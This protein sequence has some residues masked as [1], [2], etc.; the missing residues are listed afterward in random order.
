MPNVYLS[1]PV[2]TWDLDW[3]AR[4]M[5]RIDFGIR[6]LSYGLKE[7]LLWSDQEHVVNVWAAEITLDTAAE[8]SAFDDFTEDLQG[9]LVGFWLPAPEVALRVASGVDEQTFD[10]VEAGLADSFA[11]LGRTR[12]KVRIRGKESNR[13]GKPSTRQVRQANRWWADAERG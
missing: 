6:E 13:G 2:F 12:P 1:R 4:P 7:P 11:K 9:R 10:I 3:S 5:R 8:I